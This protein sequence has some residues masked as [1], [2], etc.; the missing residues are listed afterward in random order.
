LCVA[1]L[2]DKIKPDMNVADFANILIEPGGNSA[3]DTFVEVH[4][5]GPMTF[6]TFEKVTL[7]TSQTAPKKR[8]RSRNRRG[9][10][11]NKSL[12]E[13]LIKANVIFKEVLCTQ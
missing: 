1:K 4:I 2:V 5:F 13:A 6:Y 11:R 7:I 12:R 9:N 3:D 8:K 10:T